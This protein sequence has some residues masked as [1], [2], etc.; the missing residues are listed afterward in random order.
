MCVYQISVVN[1]DPVLF[2]GTIREN[3]EYG[4]K[5]CSLDEIKE[6]AM[7]ANAHDF[8]TQL[9]KG[10]DTGSVQFNSTQFNNFNFLSGCFLLLHADLPCIKTNIILENRTL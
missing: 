7:K 9:E 6:A 5:G 3:I 1:Q 2:S 10:Y 4:L 8:I